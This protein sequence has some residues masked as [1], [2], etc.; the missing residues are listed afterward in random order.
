MAGRCP[1]FARRRLTASAELRPT[2]Q[3]ALGDGEPFGHK[4]RAATHGCTSRATKF[5]GT[6]VDSLLKASRV[7]DAIND[8]FGTIA[9]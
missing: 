1:R 5:E 3:L 6:G 8:R 9:T 4:I 7:I 2:T